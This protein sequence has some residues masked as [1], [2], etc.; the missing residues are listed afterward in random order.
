M[1]GLPIVLAAAAR[2]LEALL[3]KFSLRVGDYLQNIE[4]AK[5]LVEK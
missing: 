3:Q 4:D 2:R 5:K 1:R